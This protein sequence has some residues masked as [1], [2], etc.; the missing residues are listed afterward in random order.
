[1]PSLRVSFYI[2]AFFC[3]LSA[4]LS[5]LRGERYIHELEVIK[6]NPDEDKTKE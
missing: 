6:I 5:A 4:I 2:G 3:G 1:M